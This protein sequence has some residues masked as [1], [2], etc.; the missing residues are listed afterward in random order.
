MAS[1]DEHVAA[2]KAM[3]EGLKEEQNLVFYHIVGCLRDYL[4]T[5]PS[6]QQA[7]MRRKF[8]A[9]FSLQMMFDEARRDHG[10]QV[11]TLLDAK[12]NSWS[13]CEDM[14][15]RMCRGCESLAQNNIG[16]S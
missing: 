14:A 3:V 4:D 12:T 15:E 16:K 10:V 2:L 11:I 5:V 6:D 9:A 13:W 1:K 7:E 8:L